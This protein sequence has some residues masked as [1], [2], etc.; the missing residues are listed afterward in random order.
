MTDQTQGHPIEPSELPEVI[1]GYLAAHR[2]RDAGGAITYF[3]D[4]A[5][6][7]DDGRTHRGTA[8]I[9]AWLNTSASEYTYTTELIGA[10]KVDDAHL[11]ATNHLVG[12]FPGGTV[13]LRFRFTLHGGRITELT[14]AA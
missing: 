1:T 9:L 11:V 4:D 14:I 8:E 7:V 2:N 6:V 12:N 3:A 13:D 5:T 10:A